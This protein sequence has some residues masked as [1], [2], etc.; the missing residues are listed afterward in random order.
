MMSE[1]KRSIN[2]KLLIEEKAINLRKEIWF[3]PIIAPII[4]FNKIIKYLLK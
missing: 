4:I 1:I 3:N 2:P